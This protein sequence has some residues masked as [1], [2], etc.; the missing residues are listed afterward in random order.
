MPVGT[1]TTPRGFTYLKPVDPPDLPAQTSAWAT[2]MD[3]SEG[4]LQTVE[5]AVP[6]AGAVVS[7][8]LRLQAV[9]N[10]P[11][12]GAVVPFGAKAADDPGQT[13]VFTP[14]LTG[15]NQGRITVDRTGLYLVHAA[16]LST[17]SGWCY[18]RKNGVQVQGCYRSTTSMIYNIDTVM[19][20]AAG[21]YVDV[22][23]YGT[24]S[25]SISGATSGTGTAA[26]APASTFQVTRLGNVGA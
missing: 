24:G 14:T 12:A 15:T 8:K 13:T 22:F 23:V 7:M 21:D 16:L 10:A 6:N 11:S 3:A 17:D 20:L 5:A 18:V 19:R 2:Q 25:S 26:E 9:M 4:R 1:G